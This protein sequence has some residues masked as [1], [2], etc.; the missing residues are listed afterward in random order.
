MPCGV[1]C[2]RL[3]CNNRCEK[4]LPCG[5]RCPSVCGETC[6]P[7][8]FCV[9][10]KD[11]ETMAM[12]VDMIMMAS[13]GET[14][15]DDDPILVL[16]CGHALTMATLDGM[17]EMGT[18]YKQRLDPATGNT[19]YIAKLALPG[20]EVKQ[21]SCPI[22]RKPIMQLLRYGRRIKDAQLSMRL[23]KYQILQ[24]NSM[25]DVKDQ[26]DVARAQLERGRNNFV[27]ALAVGR[28]Y[29][30]YA[31]HP[32][33]A[34]SRRLGK[35]A[36]ESD[37][38]PNSDFLTIDKTYSIP[39]EQ[40]TAWLKHILPITYVVQKL[41]EIIRRAAMPPTKQLFEAAVSRLYRLE[42]SRPSNGTKQDAVSTMLKECMRN[43]GLPADGNVGSSYVESLA[44]KTNTLLLVLSE[45]TTAL[46]QAGTMSGWY[47]F[48]QDLRNCCSVYNDITMDMALMGHFDRRAAYSRVTLLEI[49]CGHV[50]WMGRRPLPVN[51]ADRQVRLRRANSLMER[52]VVEVEELRATCPLGIK[53]DCLDR[54]GKIEKRMAVALKMARGEINQPLTKTEKLEVFRAMQATLGGS[55]HWYR[56]QN[57]HT[58]V[59][60]DCGMAMQASRCPECGAAV[61]GGSHQLL[62]NNSLDTTYEAFYRQ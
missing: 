44:E 47:W 23:K 19:L 21:V 35:Y 20:N 22:C 51:E 48:V 34:E 12:Q 33:P 28:A 45:A 6:P 2:D 30:A 52:F 39:S 59:I 49:L 25:A 55:G 60:G 41:D 42:E 36:L 5:H 29:A 14:D 4:P 37:Q 40:C 56:C 10:C 3:P 54:A 61:G 58:Y 57:G 9:E 11:P 43:C 18:Y 38:F 53:H 16:S 7:Q 26:F 62:S 17:M 31:S 13:L 27:L 15:V 24:V 1:P 32:P 50:N 46:E 8:K